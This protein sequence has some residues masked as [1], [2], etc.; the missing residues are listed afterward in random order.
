[1][2]AGE[3]IE[4]PKFRIAVLLVKSWSLKAVCIEESILAPSL[5]R[6]ILR[7][8]QNSGCPALISVGIGDPKE[9]NV[10]IIPICFS[11]QASY[12]F[13]ISQAIKDEERPNVLWHVLKIE[14]SSALDYPRL[15]PWIGI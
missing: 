2:P 10:Q 12:D 9:C 8:P 14:S 11:R 5:N 15:I 4:S 6:L 7:G 3:V 13:A 1:M